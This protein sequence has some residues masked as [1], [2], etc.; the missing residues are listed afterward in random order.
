MLKKFFIRIY[1]VHVWFAGGLTFLFITLYGIAANKTIGPRK[2]N[3]FFKFLLRNLFRLIFVPVKVSFEQA[4]DKKKAYVFMPNHVSIV[5]VPLM[6]AYIPGFSNAIEAESHFH[7][8]IYK[9]LIKSHGQIPIQRSNI[10]LS[11]KSMQI[12]EERLKNGISIIVFPEG[13]RTP[14]GE[15]QEF[16]KLPFMMAQ[17][18][19]VEIVP[20][21]IS[22]MWHFS[23][24]HTSLF[25]PASL[26]IKFGAPISTDPNISGT[27]DELML[28]VREKII[29]LV[30]RK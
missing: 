29:S 19:G 7:W 6:G 13:H 24:R 14:D 9:H 4:L 28:K 1:T 26:K 18:A 22:G 16:K 27:P 5:D 25:Y 2:S 30:E 12:A 15:I 8:P 20:L 23:P 21:G 3:G 17:R 11:L 10:R